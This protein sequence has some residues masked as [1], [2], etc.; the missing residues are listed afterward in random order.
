MYGSTSDLANSSKQAVI[1]RLLKEERIAGEHLL[2]F[3]DGPVEIRLTK[4]AGGLAVG[5]ASDEDV[6]GSGK[7][8]A[9]KR[10]QLL[11]AGADIII[12]D[13][14]EANDIIECLLG[15]SQPGGIAR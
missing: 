14:R 9:Q 6:N 15:T 4:E 10:H 8:H 3:G 1:N 2:S 11:D 7:I 5:V 12:P 13:Y